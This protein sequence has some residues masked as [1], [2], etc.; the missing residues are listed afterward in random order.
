MP[1]ADHQNKPN[2]GARIARQW[3][4]R[5]GVDV[6]VDVP[7]S[8]VALA[9]N[10]VAQD[11][12]TLYINNSAGT[13]DLTGDRCTP[14]TIYWTYITYMLA[15]SDAPQITR[16]GGDK[17]FFITADFVFGQQMARDAAHSVKG[18]GVTVLGE[19]R[20]PFRS[21]VD[22]SSLLLN[23]QASGLNVSGLA[24]RRSIRV[25]ASSRRTSSA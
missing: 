23:A 4:D 15:Q 12:N 16:A 6:I 24:A 17:W 21:T 5:D 9:V 25:P 13:G 14:V 20:Y 10:S 1:S 19:Q 18:S 22:F 2:I 7:V 8:S 3:I 11:K